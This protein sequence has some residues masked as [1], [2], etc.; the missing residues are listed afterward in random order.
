MIR[1]F[2]LTGEIAVGGAVV[3]EFRRGK[4]LEIAVNSWD[5]KSPVIPRFAAALDRAEKRL[6]G[7][8]SAF[9]PAPGFETIELVSQV[10][11]L[12][13]GCGVGGLY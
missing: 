9:V 11:A 10:A 1:G 4:T 5:L 8:S 7:D 13:L 12:S 6:P 3:A 2:V